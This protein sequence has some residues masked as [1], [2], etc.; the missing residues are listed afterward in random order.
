[1]LLYKILSGEINYCGK[2]WYGFGTHTSLRDGSSWNTPGSKVDIMFPER[3]LF[4][5]HNS[6]RN[7]SQTVEVKAL[8]VL[9]RLV[10]YSLVRFERPW[11]MSAVTHPIRLLD[12]SLVGDTRQRKGHS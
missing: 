7:Q 6:V 2:Y 10:S 1:M 9:L 3:F 4:S 5:T 12:R 11:N 8:H